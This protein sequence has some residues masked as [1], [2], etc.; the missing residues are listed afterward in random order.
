MKDEYYNLNKSNIR[1]GM[2]TM[3]I[4]STNLLK[5]PDHRV[6]PLRI[7]R[8]SLG[9]C[10]EMIS[11]LKAE[12]ETLEKDPDYKTIL[13]SLDKYRSIL[14]RKAS[15]VEGLITLLVGGKIK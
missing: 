3:R 11:G 8:K 4:H 15:Q 7:I 1:E 2:N 6:M 10:N 13:F 9:L 5:N 12:K 14:L